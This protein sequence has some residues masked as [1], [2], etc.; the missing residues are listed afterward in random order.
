M[1]TLNREGEPSRELKEMMVVNRAQEL[2]EQSSGLVELL[3]IEPGIARMLAL[4][5]NSTA[6]YAALIYSMGSGEDEI[7]DLVEVVEYDILRA[8]GY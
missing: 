6:N 7:D 1:L 2:L 5:I 3:G 8:I 4:R